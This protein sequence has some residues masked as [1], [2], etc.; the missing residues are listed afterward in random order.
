MKPST[1]LFKLISTLTKSE[2]RFFKLNS[3]LQSG[4]K[5]YL[6]I[7]DFIE[8]RNHYDEDALKAEFKNETFIKHLSSEKNHLYHLILKSL[9]SFYSEDSVSSLHKQEL[10]NIEILYDKALYSECL[11]FVQRGKALVEVN[12]K[13]YYWYELISWEK[14]LLEELLNAKEYERKFNEVLEEEKLVVEKLRNLAEYQ[15]LYSRIGLLSKN[16][17]FHRNDID[18]ILVQEIEDHHLIKGKKTALSV[19]AASI[20]YYIKGLCSAFNR[21]YVDAF[22]FFT[23]TK[24]ILDNNPKIKAD[25]GQHY[26]MTLSNLLKC[27]IDAHD[28]DNAEKIVV[29]I[30]TMEGKKG[31]NSIDSTIRIFA[32]SYNLELWLF[33][34]KGDFQKA[35]ELVPFI[36]SSWD[37]YEEKI[38]KD[39]VALF[40]F[41]KAVTFFGFGDFK[42]ALFYTNRILNNS[43]GVRKDIDS[44]SR[45][46]NLIIHYELD[47]LDFLSY[48]LKSTSRYFSKNSYQQEIENLSLNY[49]RKLS[50]ADSQIDKLRIF[51][52][53]KSELDEV[54]KN[55]FEQSILEY[56]NI[57]A[58]VESK[59]QRFSLGDAIKYKL[60]ENSKA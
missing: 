33:N 44:F 27:C 25:T 3:S 11:K 23:K 21:N 60:E 14:R 49:L 54:L 48:N 42:R 37:E 1:E 58:W 10:K 26:L 30:R 32:T 6:K 46:L 29:D 17:G 12:E 16:G 9:R 22:I 47:N 4:D 15:V 18:A 51:Q 8:S 56:F 57:A 52:D 59:L 31:F 39:Q 43:E 24:E 20:C 35:V 41:N 5:N 2:K 38:A 7:F 36:E 55:P 40:T 19:R 53:M 34:V 28:F 45:I 13:F 50:K